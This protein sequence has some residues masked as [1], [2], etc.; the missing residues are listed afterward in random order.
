MKRLKK[1]LG[2]A[3]AAMMVCTFAFASETSTTVTTDVVKG[4]LESVTGQISV[5]TIMGVLA[6]AIAASI[7]FVFMW[8]GVRK[9]LG[10]FFKGFRSGKASV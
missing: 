2:I 9:L 1:I 7:G 10:T 3:L 5:T 8:W 6:A 4:I